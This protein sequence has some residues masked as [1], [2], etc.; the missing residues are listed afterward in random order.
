MVVF[1]ECQSRPCTF[2]EDAL[3]RIFHT[4]LQKVCH[5]KAKCNICLKIYVRLALWGGFSW[6]TLG[7]R[8]I[9]D[10]PD[11]DVISPTQLHVP[12]LEYYRLPLYSLTTANQESFTCEYCTWLTT[13]HVA[14]MTTSMTRCKKTLYIKISNLKQ[15]SNLFVISKPLAT[16]LISGIIFTPARVNRRHC[17]GNILTENTINTTRTIAKHN[18]LP[19]MT[20]DDDD[21]FLKNTLYLC[22][23]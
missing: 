13:D 2:L 6:L 12:T 9:T 23:Y 19:G 14:D 3:Q 21:D 1:Q 7:S 22:Q 18:E 5:L 8:S 16:H 10:V 4:L 17:K 20:H 11:S 15:N